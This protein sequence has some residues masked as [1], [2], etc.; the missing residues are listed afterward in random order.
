MDKRTP[1]QST[2]TL[3]AQG[4]H[5]LRSFVRVLALLY[6]TYLLGFALIATVIYLTGCASPTA[7]IGEAAQQVQSLASSSGDRFADISSRASSLSTHT[8]DLADKSEL[9][10]IAASA[11]QGVGEQTSIH[12]RAGT[13]LSALP[14]VQDRATLFDKLVSLV[15]TLSIWAIVIAI[16]VIITLAGGWPLLLWAFARSRTAIRALN[17]SAKFDAP[18][19]EGEDA[20]SEDRE[21]A[22]A[23]RALSPHYERAYLSTKASVRATNKELL[24]AHTPSH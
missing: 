11:S 22:A 1:S 8:L 15:K 13:V 14:H 4:F 12:V 2:H 18:H 23:M 19:L 24:N 5:A 17:I 20:T 21:R 9:E 6:S 10:A 16:C 7:T 3:G